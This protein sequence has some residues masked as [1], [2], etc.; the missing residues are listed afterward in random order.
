MDRARIEAIHEGFSRCMLT[1]ID[2]DPEDLHDAVNEIQKRL[3]NA[4]GLRIIK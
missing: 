4:H 3:R 2:D 1:K